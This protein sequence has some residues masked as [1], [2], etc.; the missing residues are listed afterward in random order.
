MRMDID[1]RTLETRHAHDLMTS[2]LIPRPIAWVST[3]NPD[4]KT[5]L[6]PFSFFTGISWSPPILAFSPVNRADG[7][8]KDTVRNIEL[9]PEFVIHIVSA[10]LLKAMEQSAEPIPYG[11][12]ESTVGIIHLIPS[13]LVRPRRI[14]E[15][16][17]SFECTLEQIVRVTEGADAGNL[18]IGRIVL[19]HA[20]DDITKNGREIDWLGLD[21]LGRLSGSRYCTT[22]SVIESE[23]H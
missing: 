13:H 23:K 3:I 12:D 16:R 18:I 2:A 15:A 21:A 5:N 14:A 8:K 19:M 4:G 7:T 10:D 9:I 11:E 22:R 17:I 6:A 1:M 20:A